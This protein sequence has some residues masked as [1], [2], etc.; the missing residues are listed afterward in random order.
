MTAEYHKE[1]GSPA[2]VMTEIGCCCDL[3]GA[4]QLGSGYCNS[5]KVTYSNKLS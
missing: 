4:F 3:V 5:Q 2:W 1:K